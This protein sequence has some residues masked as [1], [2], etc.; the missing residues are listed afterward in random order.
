LGRL[1]RDAE[2]AT[3]SLVAAAMATP[4]DDRHVDDVDPHGRD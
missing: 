3:M 2:A 4:V 1:Y